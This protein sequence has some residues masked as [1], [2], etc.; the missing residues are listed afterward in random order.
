MILDLGAGDNTSVTLAANILPPSP[1]SG[2]SSLG[3]GTP[4]ILVLVSTSRPA[5]AGPAALQPA[6]TI[7]VRGKDARAVEFAGPTGQGVL[8]SP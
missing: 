2:S 5:R 1:R 7:R 3:G 6:R 4:P 8:R